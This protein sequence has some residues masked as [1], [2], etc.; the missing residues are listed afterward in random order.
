MSSNNQE[1]PDYKPQLDTAADQARNPSPPASTAP[2]PKGNSS[3]VD[4]VAKNV[5]V[6][7]SIL[8]SGASES[9]QQPA[10]PTQ[11]TTTTTTSP[12]E[13]P[14]RPH[15]DTQIEEFIRDQHR[16]KEIVGEDQL[17]EGS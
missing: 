9:E 2:L 15:H 13:P 16:S 17:N 6:L 5:P 14:V 1:T 11:T 10:Q 12:D 7:G 8:G 4:K 3:I